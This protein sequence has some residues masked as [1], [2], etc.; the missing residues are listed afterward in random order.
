MNFTRQAT[1][2][3][4]WTACG[5]HQSG[6]MKYCL[7][8][9]IGVSSSLKR[10]NGQSL[11]LSRLPQALIREKSRRKTLISLNI[12]CWNALLCWLCSSPSC[13]WPLSSSFSA[14]SLAGWSTSLINTNTYK[15]TRVTFNLLELPPCKL[16]L[17]IVSRP[18]STPTGQT[19]SNGSDSCLVNWD[20]RILKWLPKRRGHF[21]FKLYFLKVS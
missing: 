16:F 2:C 15:F 20:L 8:I 9:V 11:F 18:E 7:I 10:C 19:E 3:V 6:N 13:A 14:S 5:L 12:D 21:V 1:C 17:I 4:V